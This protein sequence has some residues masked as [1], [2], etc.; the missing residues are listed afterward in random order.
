V[1]PHPNGKLLHSFRIIP[2]RGTWLEVQ[3]DN[4]DLLYVYLD[5]RR[6]RRKFLI[7]TLLRSIGFSADIDI[8]NLFYEIRDLKV[9]KA[10]RSREA[11]ARLCWSRTRLTRQQGVVARPVLSSRSPKPSSAPSRTHDIASIRVIDTVGRRGC[12]HPCPQEGP[13][14]QR[15][16]GPQGNL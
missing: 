11:S 6:R 4:N 14:P 8:L 9:S 15:G 12:D 5:R 10:A 13:D 16:G 1:A 2:D 7:T 3:F